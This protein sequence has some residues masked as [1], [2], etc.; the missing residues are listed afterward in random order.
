[1]P[2]SFTVTD[3]QARQIL[4]V[5]LTDGKMNQRDARLALARYRK[6]IAELRAQ[7]ALLE[8]GEGPFPPGRPTERRTSQR[9]ARTKPV[10]PKRRKAMRRQGLYL[11]AVKP[12]KPQDRAKVK[13]VRQENG[14]AA[15]VA[16]AR[17]LAK[18]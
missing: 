10:S 16:E 7:L 4:A 1:L 5:L 14:F 18:S 15:A 2:R 12:L 6:R 9:T 3:Q 8:G 13:A 17:R 11:A